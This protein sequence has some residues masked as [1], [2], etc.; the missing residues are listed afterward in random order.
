MNLPQ[1]RYTER[2][3]MVKM[4]IAS[5]GVVDPRVLTAMLEIPRHLFVPE[6]LSSSAYDDRPLPIGHEQT[7][8]QPYIVAVMTELL[9]L[10]R[11]SRVLEIGTGSGYQA[12]ILSLLAEEVITIE[13]IPDVADS[14]ERLLKKLDITNITV[15]T[16]DGSLG[17]SPRAQYDSILVTA[18]A[19][20][21]S[22]ALIKQL[23]DD[24]RIVAPVGGRE[25]QELV[26]IEM[27]DGVIREFKHGAVCFVPLIGRYGWGGIEGC[28][29]I[30]STKNN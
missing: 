1:E 11:N 17:Y 25:V 16:G 22:C 10:K 4:Q 30:D 19:P 3:E 15:I 20:S 28:Y 9:E 26:V 14:A 21:L 2:E 27:K 24:A 13:R 18:G 5:R 29:H 12:A 23:S 8:S 7:I 6:N